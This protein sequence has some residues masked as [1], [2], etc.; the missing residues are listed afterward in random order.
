MGVLAAA[1]WVAKGVLNRPARIKEDRGGLVRDGGFEEARDGKAA[2]WTLPEK[3]ASALA[4][5]ARQGRSGGACLAI[6]KSGAA[7]DRLLICSYAQDFALGKN[8]TVEAGAWVRFESFSGWAALKIDWLREPRGPVVAEEIADAASKGSDWT[9]LRA[10]FAPPAGAGAFRLGLALLGRGGRVLVD[11]V[12]LKALPGGAPAREHRVGSHVVKPT[13]QGVLQVVLPRLA[14]YDLQAQLESDKDGVV[15]QSTAFQVSLTPQE[16]LLDFK[17]KL[18]SPIDFREI[19]FEQK[20]SLGGGG[21][22]IEYRFKGEALRQIDRFSLVMTLPRG[23]GAPDPD[24]AV[25]PRS[26]AGFRTADGGFVLEYSDPVKIA[27]RGN[28]D[29]RHRIVQSFSVDAQQEDVVFGLRIR[30]ENVGGETDPQKGAQIALRERRFG[31]ALSLLRG[32]LPGVKDPALRDKVEKEIRGVEETEVREWTETQSAGFRAELLRR[33]EA[34][35]RAREQVETYLREWAGLPASESKAA[36]LRAEL[37]KIAPASD[38]EGD[39]PRR[40]LERAKGYAEAGKRALA[41]ALLESLIGRYPESEAAGPA[42]ELLKS[43]AP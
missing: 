7:S 28:V 34:L 12:S 33:P 39:R 36:A 15:R 43:L 23:S 31:E 22:T 41:G 13:G 27:S 10:A 16:N 26:R 11:D 3:P 2:G 8:G 21:T 9:E 35:A 20:V 18:L 24:A 1:G 19:D 4:V 5:D 38:V 25:Q 17:G 6:D 30:E 14:F 42:R 32:L 40:L 29:G 37:S